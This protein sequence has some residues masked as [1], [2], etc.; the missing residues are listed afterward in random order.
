MD[1]NITLIVLFLLGIFMLYTGVEGLIS[2]EIVS[3]AGRGR[4]VSA[5]EHA[6]DYWLSICLDFCI[7]FFCLRSVIFRRDDFND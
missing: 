1:K 6:L 4:V 7:S 3:F 2:E 5:S